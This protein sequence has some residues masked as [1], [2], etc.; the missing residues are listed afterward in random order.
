[1]REEFESG[2]FSPSV[3]WAASSYTEFDCGIRSDVLVK[4]VPLRLENDP[5]AEALFE[6]RFEPSTPSV[7]DVLPGIMF[8][9]L[10]ARFPVVERLP[11]AQL[12]QAVHQK[13]PELRYQARTRLSNDQFVLM[14]SDYA[15]TISCLKPYVGWENFR[16]LILEV[17]GHLAE[18]KLVAKVE[19][20]SLKYINLLPASPEDY[21]KQF[22]YVDFEGRVGSFSLN[23]ALTYVRTE[24]KNGDYVTVLELAAGA[25]A[26]TAKGE[27]LAGAILSIDTISAVAFDRLMASPEAT[28]NAIR[29][30]EKRVFY[31]V[32]SEE[33]GRMFG[34]VWS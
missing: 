3:G 14:F 18:S 5:I 11:F 33:A 10:G 32:L 19:R 31:D 17:L 12:P 34:A 1:V 13:A 21:A 4:Q 26:R 25:S 22:S 9:K 2:P 20:Y 15:L 29:A 7:S 24:I 28:V 23:R 6:V 8:G 27:E 30:E 16:P